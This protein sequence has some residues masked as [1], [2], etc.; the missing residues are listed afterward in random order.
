VT[1]DVEEGAAVAEAV[2]EVGQ[3]VADTVEGAE[4]LDKA[5]GDLPSRNLSPLAAALCPTVGANCRGNLETVAMGWLIE[6]A[7]RW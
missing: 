3:V 2:L 5:G 1:A 7:R 6:G 4:P